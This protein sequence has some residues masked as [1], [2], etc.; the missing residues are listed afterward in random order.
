MDKRKIILLLKEVFEGNQKN[1]VDALKKIF[2]EGLD[3]KNF[4][5]DVL[6]ILNLFSRKLTLGSLDKDLSI[7]ESELSSINEISKNLKISDIN[8]FWH[9]TIKSINDIKVINNEYLLLE[10]YI[11]QLCHL[12]GMREFSPSEQQSDNLVVEN[13]GNKLKTQTNKD[14]DISSKTIKDQLKSTQQIKTSIEKK[15]SIEKPYDKLEIN[16]INSLI[17]IV[18][19]EKEV[20]E[21]EEEN[22]ESE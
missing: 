13:K 4:L 22:S 17:E 11:I 6:Y 20:D 5:N 15:P 3:A 7:S 16:S 21:N 18:E 9:L 2:N 12:E 8:L 19:K 1:A 10:M 14:K